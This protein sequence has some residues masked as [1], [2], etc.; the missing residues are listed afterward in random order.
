MKIIG[1]T[2]ENIK[3]LVAVEIEPTG[4]VVQITGKNGNGKT[5]A[6]VPRG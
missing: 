5:S 3:R 4:A 2:A 6:L 1:L